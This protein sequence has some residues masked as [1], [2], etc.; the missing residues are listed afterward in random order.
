MEIYPLLEHVLQ[1]DERLI[2]SPL[3]LKGMLL[4]RCQKEDFRDVFLLTFLLQTGIVKKIN[5]AHYNYLSEQK[6]VKYV[7]HTY[8]FDQELI[9][10]SL[11]IWAKVLHQLQMKKN[12]LHNFTFK[13]PQLEEAIK[14]SIYKE[15]GVPLTEEDL[16]SLVVLRG[17]HFQ[18][19]NLSGIEKLINVEHI[20][21]QNNEIVDITPLLFLPHLKTLFISHNKVENMSV[22][23][24]FHAIQA[25]DFSYNPVK[26]IEKLSDRSL[27]LMFDT[28]GEDI[29]MKAKV[30]SLLTERGY[31]L[32][33][34]EGGQVY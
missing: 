6:L 15:R 27:M 22:I 13:D 4:D 31:D 19:S 11:R 1:E 26:D 33:I 7:Y 5:V 21:L 2:H 30:Y 32:V 17:D 16:A 20:S 9:S 3:R 25:I 28:I 29:S 8:G 34:D 12:H 10:R 18:I 14:A 23:N 24:E